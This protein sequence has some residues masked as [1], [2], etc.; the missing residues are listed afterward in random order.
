MSAV[1][2]DE[3]S[4]VVE[5]FFHPANVYPAL[6]GLHNVP[7]SSPFSCVTVAFSQVE[8]PFES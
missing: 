7:H 6:V 5:P 2:F 4:T 8:P 3:A 1:A